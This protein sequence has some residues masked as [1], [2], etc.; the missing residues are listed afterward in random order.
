MSII[1]DAVID[2]VQKVCS[3]DDEPTILKISDMHLHGEHDCWEHSS[4]Y[5][6]Y[7]MYWGKRHRFHGYECGLCGQHLQS[8]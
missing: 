8:G 6:F 1:D 2:I 4:Y 7:D 3:G 5:E